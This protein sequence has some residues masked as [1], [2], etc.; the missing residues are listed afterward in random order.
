MKNRNPNTSGSRS[1]AETERRKAGFM[2]VA[3]MTA[4]AL[5]ACAPTN[6]EPTPPPTETSHSAE[7]PS[8]ENCEDWAKSLDLPKLG[9]EQGDN[10]IKLNS[11]P[12]TLNGTDLLNEANNFD[13]N[14]IND[15]L[16]VIPSDKKVA[17]D[18]LYSTGSAEA[19]AEAVG[20]NSIHEI[21]TATITDEGN[22]VA[23]QVQ[24]DVAKTIT[25]LTYL[26]LQ[27]KVMASKDPKISILPRGDASLFNASD[28]LVQGGTQLDISLNGRD[29]FLFTTGGSFVKSKDNSKWV[30]D[31]PA[32]WQP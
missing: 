11:L 19:F 7:A 29:S 26:A 16:K 1:S 23:Q 4:A 17:E 22:E 2:T 12:A 31:G 24:M 5:A 8:I 30:F 32:A 3:A 10:F 9:T 13:V 28:G 27:D 14:W 6:G 18:C 25:D 20:L 15:A 21:R